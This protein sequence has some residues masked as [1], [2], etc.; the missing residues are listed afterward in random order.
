MK[1]KKI[2]KKICSVYE[3]PY[4]WN[5]LSMKCPIYEMSHLRAVPSMILLLWHVFLWNVPTGVKKLLKKHKTEKNDEL[6]FPLNSSK[7]D[8]FFLYI[9]SVYFPLYI[10]KHWQRKGEGGGGGGTVP[11]LTELCKA[12]CS[13]QQIALYNRKFFTTG[14]CTTRT[15]V[16]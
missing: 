16:T 3:M 7:A 15:S 14:N 13:V 5:V 10:S 2:W 11:I 1:I 4:L 9:P 6:I 12:G 8:L